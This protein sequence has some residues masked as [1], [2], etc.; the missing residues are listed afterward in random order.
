MTS[1]G[2]KQK[3]PAATWRKLDVA[4]EH[5]IVD[6][7]HVLY[8]RTENLYGRCGLLERGG[9]SEAGWFAVAIRH[10]TVV[11]V[12]PRFGL[13]GERRG[14]PGNQNRSDEEPLGHNVPHGQTPWNITGSRWKFN[15]P[16]ER[17]RKI[18]NF[19]RFWI[20]HVVYCWCCACIMYLFVYFILL[21]SDAFMHV[22][23]ICFFFVLNNV[24]SFMTSSMINE[25][26]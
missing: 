19:A 23:Y 12:L 26:V 10:R 25:N 7:P 4:Q 24:F 14:N 11:W 3:T 17:I 8:N 20:A 9:E 22:F 1:A 15:G 13:R 2:D 16:T 18:V 6:L 21:H 5:R